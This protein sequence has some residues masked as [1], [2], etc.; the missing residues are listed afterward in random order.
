MT[1]KEFMER[2]PCTD[3][4]IKLDEY[5]TPQDVDNGKKP[6]TYVL[7][8]NELDKF[9]EL[10][11]SVLTALAYRIIPYTDSLSICYIPKK[12]VKRHTYLIEYDET[13]REAVY[14]L[15]ISEEDAVDYF[16]TWKSKNH[17]A[18]FVRADV[19]SIKLMKPNQ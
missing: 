1:V 8:A 19:K 5:Y 15:G 16:H 3:L 13:H 6:E 10:P 17:T 2:I 4:K 12:E 14:A 9:K 11:L 7:E 18:N